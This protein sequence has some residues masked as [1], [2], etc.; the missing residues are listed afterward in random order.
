MRRWFYCAAVLMLV[1]TA[2]PAFAQNAQINGVIKDQTG[3]IIPGA[4]VTGKNAD[5]GFTRV[6]VSEANGEYRLPSL[7][8]GRYT[9]TVELQGFSTESRP[10]L[11]LVIDQTA[12]INF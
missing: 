8:P 12:I 5:N 7:P 4:T 3:G 11:V 2:V 1:G 6:S 9:V 10:D